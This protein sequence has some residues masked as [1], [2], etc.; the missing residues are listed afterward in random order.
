MNPYSRT[1]LRSIGLGIFS[2]VFALIYLIGIELAVES[3]WHDWETTSWF[4][5]NLTTL[6]APVTAGVLVGAVYKYLKLP[7]RFHGFI[8]EL[9]EGKVEPSTAPGAIGI[10]ILSLISGPSLGPEAPLGTAGGAAGTWLAR[11]SGGDAE[12]V[13]QMSF[14]GMSG[15]FGGLLSTPIGGPLMAF[16]LE[17]D[18]SHGYYFQHLVPGMI[19]GGV[20]FGIMWPVIG[21]PFA[22]LLAIP[23]EAFASWMLLAAAGIGVFGAAAA[24]IVGKVLV[25]IVDAMRRLDGKPIL[26][27]TIAGLAIAVTAFALPL[28]MFSGQTTLPVVIEEYQSLGVWM[29][30]A[31]A[32]F[33]TVALGASLG[34]GFYGGPIFPIF[35]IGAALGLAVNILFPAIPA[36]LAVAATMAALGAAVATLP[37]SMAILAALMVGSGI[38]MFGAVV[39]AAAVAFA[40]RYALTRPDARGDVQTSAAPTA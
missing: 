6:I 14:I 21:A 31:L 11:R 16:E 17:H 37:L 13:R 39:I 24:V 38:E 29:L 35:F 32:I 15:M 18:Q 22:G 23:Q 25:K 27:G 40:I 3:L 8:E 36:G 7:P 19:S 20:A 10:A 28:T 12:E 34:G 4:S 30:L 26:R 33:K 1:V 9:Q 5:G 2:G